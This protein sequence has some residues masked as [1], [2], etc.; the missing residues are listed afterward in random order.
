VT[1]AGNQPG[2]SMQGTFSLPHHI[3]NF[4]DCIR[5]GDRPTADI[6]IAHLTTS[7]CHLGNIATRVGRIV[8]FD[9][10][11]EQIADDPE[12]AKLLRR[13]YRPGHWAA[14]KGV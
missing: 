11:T 14:P 7:L 13:E 10:R 6:E 5:S 8:R 9:P 12:A 1:L 2:P 3:Q 4:L